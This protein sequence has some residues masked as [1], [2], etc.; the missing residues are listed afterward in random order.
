MTDNSYSYIECTRHEDES[1][2]YKW[3][4]D[5]KNEVG[6]SLPFPIIGDIET[7]IKMFDLVEMRRTKDVAYFKQRRFVELP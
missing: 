6:I 2:T 4:G 7:V 3:V 1:I 5:E